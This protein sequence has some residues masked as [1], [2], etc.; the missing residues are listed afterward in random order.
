[1]NFKILLIIYSFI[2]QNT[3][4]MLRN[5]YRNEKLEILLSQSIVGLYTSALFAN[6]EKFVFLGIELV[7]YTSSGKYFSAE[8]RPVDVLNNSFKIAHRPCLSLYCL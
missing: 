7:L 8:I 1:M 4:N 2:Q 5:K 3:R 6:N